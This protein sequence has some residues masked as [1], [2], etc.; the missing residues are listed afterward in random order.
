MTTETSMG[1]VIEEI[2]RLLRKLRR[3]EGS[4]PDGLGIRTGWLRNPEGPQAAD[5]IESQAKEI[6]RLREALEGIR[7]FGFRHPDHGH[8]CASRADHALE[9]KP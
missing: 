4:G 9:N 3:V 2:D 7:A 6:A 1:L 5:T 8:W